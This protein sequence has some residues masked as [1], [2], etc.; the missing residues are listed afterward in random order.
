MTIYHP[1]RKAD[2]ILVGSFLRRI[3]YQ[4]YTKL[5]SEN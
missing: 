3:N 5:F 1:K 4:G 2:T